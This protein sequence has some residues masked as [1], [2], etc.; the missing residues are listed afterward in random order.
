[1]RLNSSE[2]L[3]FFRDHHDFRTKFVL[4][5]R[6]R[7]FFC[8]NRDVLENHDLG[9]RHKIWAKLYYSLKFFLAG[10]LMEGAPRMVCS[11]APHWQFNEV[12]G[13]QTGAHIQLLFKPKL[14]QLY[15]M[16]WFQY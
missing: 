12:T 2:D 5:P 13:H 9:N 11:M 10:T 3:F 14:G 1:M 7:Q 16:F 15:A 6:I 8:P 4:C